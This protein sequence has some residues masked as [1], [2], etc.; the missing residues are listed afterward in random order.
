MSRAAALD[1]GVSTVAKTAKTRE[2]VALVPQ[3]SNGRERVVLIM[4]A[5]AEVIHEKGFEA[6]TMKEIAARSGTKIGSLYRFFPT[7]ETLGNA[8]IDRSAA[9]SEA[10]W[11]AINAT[12]PTATTDQLAELLLYASVRAREHRP[13]FPTL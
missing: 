9:F 6:A 12:A 10:Q 3:R 5:A 13:V 2:K 1:A 11:Q 7:T 4:A 8:L